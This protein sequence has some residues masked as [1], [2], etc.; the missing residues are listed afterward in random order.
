MT[1]MVRI[2]ELEKDFILLKTKQIIIVKRIFLL[3]ATVI[4]MFFGLSGC[5]EHFLEGELYTFIGQ[6]VAGY[7]EEHEETFSDFLYILDRSGRLSLM[8]AYGTYTC[9]APTNEAVERFLIE[10]DSIWRASQEPGAKPKWTG[11][12]S[13][14]LTEL[15]DSM[16]KV[17]ADTHLMSLKYLT[18]DLGGDVMPSKNMNLRLLTLNYGVDEEG[19]AVVYVNKAPILMGDNEV[20]NGIVH[21][22]GKVM[23]SSSETVPALIDE[24]SFLTIFSQALQL[25]GLDQAMSGDKDLSY[26]YGGKTYDKIDVWGKAPYPKYRMYGYTAFCESDEVFR[27]AG[28]N[29]VED[30]Y[31]KCKVW[32]PNA[33]DEDFKSEN[34]A[35]HKFM[36]YH[37]LNRKLT[38]ARLVCY[39]MYNYY[40]G[41]L[42]YNSEENFTRSQ[43]RYEYYETMQGP[44]VK[45][46]RPLSN[47]IYGRNYKGSLLELNRCVLLNYA[48]ELVNRTDPFHSVA[49]ANQI[50]V[51]VMVLNPLDVYDD[52]EC[53]PG[54]LQEALNGSILLIDRPLV[55]DEDVMAGSVLNEQIRCDIIG[56]FP[57][58]TNND[59]RWSA[60]DDYSMENNRSY[61]AFFLPP[62]Y[63]DGLKYNTAETMSN[64]EIYGSQGESYQGDV[65]ICAKHTDVSIR[66]PR[67]PDGTYEIR[68]CYFVGDWR[69]I[70][71]FYV[72]DQI[73]GIPIDLRIH[74]TDP[75]V[76]FEYDH[77][78]SDNGVDNDKQMKNRGY[79]K[80]A[81]A[82]RM[83]HGNTKPRDQ[84]TVL[85]LVL[86]K[87]Y[88][89]EGE[90]HWIRIKSVSDFGGLDELTFDYIELVPVGWLRREDLSLEEKRR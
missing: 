67:V 53:Y 70:C 24:M 44:M 58:L 51:N 42:L 88:L 26:S 33:T 73:T 75:L 6:T 61:P 47:P 71:Q 66:L 48:K 65:L 10:Q 16:C 32:Y 56:L 15:S 43:D 59:I 55:Y 83:W 77:N 21:V 64:V 8:K 7:L 76:G 74:G 80:S 79:L 14:V 45:A 46:I 34:N 27:T 2:T 68:M 25:A 52:P 20:E 57:E 49:G 40:K 23:S 62:G 36:A 72:D 3:F 22:I 63:C 11:V 50:P 5:S 30:L 29:N 86:T 17:I 84:E 38:Y 82:Y 60:C 12:T 1:R 13:P 87:K 31:K 89:H 90:D 41:N 35:L 69:G 9:F 4:S 28:I 54:Y 85:R 78:T 19:H 39:N 37:L 81:D 18:A